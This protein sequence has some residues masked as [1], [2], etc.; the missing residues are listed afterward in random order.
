MLEGYVDF[1][2]DPSMADCYVKLKQELDNLL[3]KKVRLKIDC[4]TQKQL[5]LNVLYF[6]WHVYFLGS[7]GS[8]LKNLS[9]SP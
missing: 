1:F 4:H 6:A 9:L 8:M 5:E 3:Q 2:M 7:W